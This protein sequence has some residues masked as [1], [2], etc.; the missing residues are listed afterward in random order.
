MLARI[1]RQAAILGSHSLRHGGRFRACRADRL[2]ISRSRRSRFL[3]ARRHGIHHLRE[4]AAPQP[5][6]HL[7]PARSGGA[8]SPGH[9]QRRDHG[10]RHLRHRVLRPGLLRH[11]RRHARFL[12]AARRAADCRAPWGTT[13]D[14]SSGDFNLFGTGS[15]APLGVN[16]FTLAADDGAA[17][18]DL[19]MASNLNVPTL[20]EWGMIILSLML[21][22]GAW[23]ALRRQAARPPPS[24]RVPGSLE[25]PPWRW[26]FRLDEWKSP[27]KARLSKANPGGEGGIR[28]RVRLLT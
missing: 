15:P 16:W 19:R 6:Q 10:Q 13:Y 26:A 1:P 14:G 12:P 25:R 17:E 5:G 4:H 11:E 2:S 28:T 27:R 21:G 18:G 7:P 22:L 9:R 23:I 20:G 3:T 8:G 24:I